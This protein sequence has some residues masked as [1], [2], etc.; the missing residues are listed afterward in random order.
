MNDAISSGV[1]RTA[2]AECLVEDDIKPTIK[3]QNVES[4][5]EY[6]AMTWAAGV[7]CF[8]IGPHVV[9]A[10]IEFIILTLPLKLDRFMT[11][12]LCYEETE[13]TMLSMPRFV[14]CY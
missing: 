6:F 3:K 8:D 7:T 2:L 4:V 12:S 13:F 10:S 14:C 1:P 11:S 9:P 5:G